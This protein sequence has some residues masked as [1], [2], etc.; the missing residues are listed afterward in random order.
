ML[1]L[2]PRELDTLSTSGRLVGPRLI[3]AGSGGWTSCP[4]ARPDE[5]SR[6]RPGLPPPDA[7]ARRGCECARTG[8]SGIF[9]FILRMAAPFAAWPVAGAEDEDAGAAPPSAVA[10]AAPAAAAFDS[11][12]AFAAPS[13]SARRFSAF[14]FL[15]LASR[16]VLRASSM[17]FRKSANFF[18]VSAIGAFGFSAYR[19]MHFFMDSVTSSTW[20]RRVL[21]C[22]CAPST[23]A[24]MARLK[25]SSSSF[26]GGG[27]PPSGAAPPPTMSATFAT[28]LSSSPRRRT[29]SSKSS[30]DEAS[31]SLRSS[32]ASSRTVR[33]IS[34]VSM[35][36]RI[37]EYVLSP[38]P[39]TRTSRASVSS[40]KP[41]WAPF[42]VPWLR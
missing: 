9:T 14:S 15:A 22:P 36:K 21:N 5:F 27:A 12:L 10:A 13:F 40:V 18:R 33:S 11:A 2:P 35:R 37:R 19:S 4:K 34:R 3:L 16:F 28:A 26:P 20:P 24:R 8:L 1:I 42:L 6:R 39:S 30:F 29:Q 7:S 17:S 31:Q 32:R 23:K 41:N 38:A 25:R